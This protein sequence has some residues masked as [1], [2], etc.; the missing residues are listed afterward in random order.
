MLSAYYGSLKAMETLPFSG[1]FEQSIRISHEVKIR[2]DFGSLSFV[3][4]MKTLKEGEMV[5]PNSQMSKRK[6]FVKF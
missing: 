1:D 6:R 2:F 4:E 5:D 3:Q